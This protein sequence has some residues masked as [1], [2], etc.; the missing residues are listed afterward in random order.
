VAVEDLAVLKFTFAD[1]Q[2]LDPA[3]FYWSP[4]HETVVSD[5]KP[6]RFAD[7]GNLENTG[8]NGMLAYADIDT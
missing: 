6:T 4:A 8:I 1:L 5:P 3:Y 2:S 7:G